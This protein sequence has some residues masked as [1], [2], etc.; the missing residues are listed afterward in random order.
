[1]RAPKRI[2]AIVDSVLQ[3]PGSVRHSVAVLAAVA[4][5]TEAL[6]ALTDG[7]VAAATGFTVIVAL[8]LAL[9][10]YAAGGGAQDSGYRRSV[11]LL[12]GRAPALGGWQ[13]IVAKTLGDDSEV[14]LRTVMRPQLQRLFA[15]RLAERH[16]VELFRTPQRARVLVGAELWPWIDPEAGAPQPALPEPVLRALLDRLETL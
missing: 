3:A 11:R 13:H 15:A 4:V 16:G 2:R 1:M 12:G 8:A 6:L 10:R 7:A 9:A 5:A 14:H